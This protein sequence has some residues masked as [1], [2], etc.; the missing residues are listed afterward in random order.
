MCLIYPF[1]SSNSY[2]E[3]LAIQPSSLLNGATDYDSPLTAYLTLAIFN[4][5]LL[6]F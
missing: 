6:P 1:T 2:F 4:R 3:V 5:S